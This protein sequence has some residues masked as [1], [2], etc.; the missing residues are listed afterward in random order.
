MNCKLEVNVYFHRGKGSTSNQIDSLKKIYQSSGSKVGGI[1]V[2]IL[3]AVE[4]FELTQREREKWKCLRCLGKK[5]AE[6]DAREYELEI[7]LLSKIE[8]G[9]EETAGSGDG[10]KVSEG[11]QGKD[12]QLSSLKGKVSLTLEQP[13]N[14][15]IDFRGCGCANLQAKICLEL[16]KHYRKAEKYGKCLTNLLDA[17][18]SAISIGNS[19]QALI[20]LEDAVA[21]QHVSQRLGEWG[22]MEA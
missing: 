18:E 2:D 16:V 15:V 10:D 19:G 5:S 14:N 17:S 6:E 22:I 20:H 13:R 3:K 9:R 21:L 4:T 11:P 1:E 12:D 7:K 8:E